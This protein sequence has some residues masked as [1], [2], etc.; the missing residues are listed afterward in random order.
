LGVFVTI[1]TS[2]ES[3]EVYHDHC[4]VIINI[5]AML[6]FHDEFFYVC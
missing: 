5:K 2:F 4:N 1:W 6:N 3:Y